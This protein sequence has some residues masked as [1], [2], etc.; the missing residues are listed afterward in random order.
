VTII[1]KELDIGGPM[2][3]G[4]GS[5]GQR[6]SGH[7]G[8]GQVM[9]SELTK[10]RTLRSTWWS[11]LVMTIGMLGV[12]VLSVE[13]ATHRQKG[14]YQGFDPTAQSLT[15]LA[16]GILVMGVLG[17]LA[18]SG[19]YGT[20]TIRSSLCA[21]PLRR[22]F[23]A[24]K[25]LVVGA[26]SVIVGEI[27]SFACFGLGQVL[28]AHGGAPSAGLGQPGV[29]RAV[30]ESGACLGLLGLL[31]LGLGFVVRHTA[32]AIGSY[33]GVTLLLPLLIHQLP[34]NPSRFTPVGILANSVAEVVRQ[35]GQISPTL[36]FVL[37]ALYSAVVLALGMFLLTGRDA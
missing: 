2:S 12:T 32:G 33:V 27:L 37:M 21:V 3:G 31:G 30:L 4:Q 5:S 17:A 11:L 7:C 35:P 22:K 19:E 23:L 24:G 1:S 6:W 20:G 15:G 8:L 10:M 16:M 25:L 14:W 28:L 13:P 29:L 36:G 34:G 9:R 18:I 26:V